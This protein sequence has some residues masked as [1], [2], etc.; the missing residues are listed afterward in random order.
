MR[1]A[2]FLAQGAA[3]AALS[4]ALLTPAGAALPIQKWQQPSGAQVWLIES[5]S[6]PMVDVEIDFDAGDRRDPADKA[7]LAGVT[8]DMDSKG[9]EARNGEPA[10]DE[11]QLGEAWA[12]LGASFGAG[13]SLDRMSFTLRS[14]TY[15]DLLTKAVHLAS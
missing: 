13:A 12:D 8:A 4:C 10:L 1:F 14:L 15:P 7:G 2:N 11:N 5:P 3:A 9:I 6:L